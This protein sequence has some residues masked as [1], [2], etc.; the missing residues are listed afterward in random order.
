MQKQKRNIKESKQKISPFKDYWQSH[1]YIILIFGLLLVV[2]GYVL[3][4]QDPWY[5]P[6]SLTISPIVLLV[7]YIIV[8]PFSI[9]ITKKN[10]KKDII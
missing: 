2:F 5:N 4:A 10:S 3:M 6:I 1:N 9:I 8:I 7:A